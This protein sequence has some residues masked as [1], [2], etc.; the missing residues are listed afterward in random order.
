MRG[1][2]VARRR[3]PAARSGERGNLA[4]RACN[5]RLL[6]LLRLI[7]EVCVW[8]LLLLLIA[9]MFAFSLLLQLILLVLL[10]MLLLLL[11]LMLVLELQP[12]PQL[13]QLP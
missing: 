2:L 10:L 11:L 4:A 5:D 3:H 1:P 6:A 7:A 12:Q 8:L 13:E 9:G